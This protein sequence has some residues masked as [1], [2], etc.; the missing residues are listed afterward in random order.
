MIFILQNM[1]KTQ[2]KMLYKKY[3]DQLQLMNDQL[4]HIQW[5]TKNKILNHTMIVQSNFVNH[6]NDNVINWKSTKISIDQQNMKSIQKI[7][8]YW[9][10]N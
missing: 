9:Q 8:T 2:S 5:I 4:K 10:Y 1:L 6:E 3:Y 7:H